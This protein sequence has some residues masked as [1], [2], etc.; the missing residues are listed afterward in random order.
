MPRISVPVLTT[1]RACISTTSEEGAVATFDWT[2]GTAAAGGVAS[3]GV[4]VACAR[5]DAGY[6]RAMVAIAAR[7]LHV[8]LFIFI[9]FYGW[10]WGNES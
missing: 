5:S 2:V 6:N 10:G 7:H 4:V 3:V 9:Q 1:S 8:V